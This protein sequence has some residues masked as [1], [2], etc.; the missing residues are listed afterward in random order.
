MNKCKEWNCTT[1]RQSTGELWCINHG[2]VEFVRE[3]HDAIDPIGSLMSGRDT[4]FL[5]KA[6]KNLRA[7]GWQRADIMSVLNI[8]EKEYQSHKELNSV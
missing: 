2:T 3:A 8:N 7:R 1:I 5:E 6:I 4:I